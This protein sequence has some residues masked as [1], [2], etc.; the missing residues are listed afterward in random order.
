MYG[1]EYQF[2]TTFP[3]LPGKSN[4]VHPYEWEVI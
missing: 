4:A 1:L 2:D 3:C